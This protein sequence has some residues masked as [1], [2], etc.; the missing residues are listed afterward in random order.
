MKPIA[1]HNSHLIT[2]L[3]QSFVDKSSKLRIYLQDKLCF[4]DLTV[5]EKFLDFDADYTNAEFVECKDN[6][7]GYKESD[8]IN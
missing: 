4:P 1:N 3:R 5:R 7:R 8:D 6:Y 2:Y